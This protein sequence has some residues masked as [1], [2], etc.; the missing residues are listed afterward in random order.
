MRGVQSTSDAKAMPADEAMAGDEERDLSRPIV[1]IGALPPPLSGYSLITGKILEVARGY[2]KV[3]VFDISP[4]RSKRGLAYHFTRIARVFLAMLRLFP[5]RLDRARE[6]YIA[7]E[8]RIGL[9]YTIAL[10]LVARGLGY[11]IFLHHHVF[12]YIS[13]RNRLMALLVSLTRTRATHIFLCTCME[14]GFKALYGESLSAL[15]LSN[16]AFIDPPKNYVSPL[17]PDGAPLKVGLLSNLT[18]EKGLYEFLAMAKRTAADGLA[19][20][21]LLAGPLQSQADAEA[22]R[23][24]QLNL[25]D[26]FEYRGPVY[27]AEKEKFYRDIEV[28]VLPSTYENE[29]QPLVLFEALSYGCP[30]LAYDRGCMKEQIGLCGAVIAAQ[31][32]FVEAALP[33][34]EAWQQDRRALYL[35]RTK[36][37]LSLAD[38]NARSARKVQRLLGVARNARDAR[39]LLTGSQVLYDVVRW[40]G[41]TMLERLFGSPYL[42][43]AHEALV[44]RTA[45]AASRPQTLFA[46]VLHTALSRQFPEAFRRA[47]IAF[48]HIPK[49]A[50]TSIN[51]AL[52]GRSFGHMTAAFLREVDAHAY[53]EVESFAALRDPVER[54]VSA[55]SHVIS[56]GGSEV[57]LHP[58]WAQ[59]LRHIDSFEAYLSYLEENRERLA[60]LTVALRPQSQFVCD[61]AG[62]VLVNRLFLIGRDDEALASFVAQRAKF[63]LPHR[64]WT[65][66]EFFEVTMAQRERIR[67]LYADDVRLI[68]E[69]MSSRRLD[70]L[71]EK[72]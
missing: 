31:Q 27:G 28:F 30:V 32:D 54:A 38:E 45:R 13:Q 22:I 23:E 14:E 47:G 16:A 64:N 9:V 18:R 67:A 11:R 56:G 59:R 44:V 33:M 61:S 49:N 60:R 3:I 37:V 52:Y 35:L 17:V 65:T 40:A 10:S 41:G 29:A 43:D 26:T 6:L 68:E 57:R 19:L 7:T 50:G 20:R 62:R 69:T 63:A 21:F 39:Q 58:R 36:A 8:S 5:A 42:S 51:F 53:S 70:A 15:R 24:A 66:H 12:R 4:G 2:R 71:G 25:P 72:T 1:I 46:P 34:L 48:I 55:Y